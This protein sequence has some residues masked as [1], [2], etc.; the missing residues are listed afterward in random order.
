[1]HESKKREWQIRLL[2]DIKE[3][4]NGKF[5]TLTFNEEWLEKLEK[6][7]KKEIDIINDKIEE[8]LVATYAVRH[9]LERW[10]FKYKKSVRHWLVT[11]LGHEN[12]ERIHLHGIIYTDVPSKCIL[13]CVS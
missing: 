6:E 3:Y 1:M 9:F 8:N 5:V 11:E 7:V 2:E 10:R 12:T 13:S 4:K